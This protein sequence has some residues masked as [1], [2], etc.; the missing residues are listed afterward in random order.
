MKCPYC[1]AILQDED[2]NFC[3]FCGAKL[4]NATGSTETTSNQQ[5]LLPRDLNANQFLSEEHLDSSLESDDIFQTA[6]QSQAQS[7]RIDNRIKQGRSNAKRCL[8]FALLSGIISSIALIAGGL[9]V[10]A[11]LNNRSNYYHTGEFIANPQIGAILLIIPLVMNIIG[12]I[13]GI[14]AKIFNRRS[15][16]FG[17]YGK[18]YRTAGSVLATFG[19]IFSV[20]GIIAGG[21]GIFYSLN[22]AN[23]PPIPIYEY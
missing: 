11:N 14:M 6:Y 20:V 7:N 18:S 22:L 3:Q 17:Y 16:K 13:F 15:A 19:I 21:F 4:S 12:F 23:N 8:L 10:F 9:L 2:Q 5:E 1:G